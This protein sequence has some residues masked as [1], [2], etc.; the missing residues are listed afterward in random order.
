MEVNFRALMA[1]RAVMDEGTIT[2]AAV[3]L[4]RSQPVVSR[5]IAQ[6]E[7][8]AGFA[9]FRRYRQRL[10]P[11]ADGIAFYREAERVI[12]ALADIEASA[13]SIHTRSALPLRIMAQSH[14]AHCLLDEALPGFCKKHPEFRFSLEIRPREYIS[15]WVANRQ[16]DVGFVPMPV[17][18]PQLDAALLVR[19]PVYAILPSGHRLSRKRR[20]GVSDM[21]L[22]P[23][24]APRPGLPMRTRIDGWFGVKS[25]IAKIRGET[26]S[27]LSACQLAAQG[28]G[29]TF[30]D[31]FVAS[32]FI[33]NGNVVI[34]PLFPA[35]SVDYVVLRRE[36]ERLG[37]LAN[38]FVSAVR[39][40]ARKMVAQAAHASAS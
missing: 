6:L 38:E 35:V 14:I 30:A 5:L 26:A 16:F 32:R 3:R 28:V 21:V 2:A 40:T 15:H 22:E 1:L 11:T 24:V 17:E 12:A 8:A 34:R 29:P 31:P 9:M 4:H 25:G 20:L 23:I 27:I 33:S 18:H 36:G 13:N 10:I 19:A 39:M 7:A 37:A